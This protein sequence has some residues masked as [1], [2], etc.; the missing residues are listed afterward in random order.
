M[1]GIVVALALVAASASAGDEIAARFA[2]ALEPALTVNGIAPSMYAT[3]ELGSFR[4]WSAVPPMLSTY[5]C[6]RNVALAV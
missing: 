4:I 1:R 6:A 2:K 5:P 3:D